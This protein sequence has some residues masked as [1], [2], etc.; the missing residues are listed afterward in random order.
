MHTISVDAVIE[1][2]K[3]EGR[4]KEIQSTIKA[5]QKTSF[6]SLP[7]PVEM[8]YVSLTLMDDYL[9]DMALTQRFAPLNRK[10]I[11]DVIIK[12]MK[13]TVK[14]EFTTVHNYI[15]LE[16]MILRKVQYQQRRERNF[17]F[18]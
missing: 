8:A 18:R 9:G 4:E 10:A 11:S 6:D 15:D 12:K 7:F 3:A 14:D 1:R 17:L 13:L 16:S 5:L 2:L